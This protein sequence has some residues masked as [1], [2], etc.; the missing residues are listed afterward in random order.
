MKRA[1]L[2][3]CE[4]T[5]AWAAAWRQ[6]ERRRAAVAQR[7]PPH[8]RCLETRSAAE[9]L[10]QLAETPASFVLIELTTASR[11]RALELLSQIA[12]RHRA[13]LPAVA[14]GRELADHE[15]LVRELG[16]VH[17]IISPREMPAL[18]RMI[19][20]YAQRAPEVELELEERIWA[21]LPWAE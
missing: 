4:R 12:L 10:E 17:F 14:A 18:G 5:G 3:V 16:A 19:E 2:I 1:T 20:R 13:A 21:E 11:E 6:W 9:C 15:W 7:E 8:V